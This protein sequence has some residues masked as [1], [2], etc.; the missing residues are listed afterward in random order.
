MEGAGAESGSWRPRAAGP[1]LQARLVIGLL[2]LSLLALVA[3]SRQS[4]RVTTSTLGDV[5]QSLATTP[6]STAPSSTTTAPVAVVA[7]MGTLR[8]PS[9][10]VTMAASVTATELK[11]IEAIKGVVAVEQVDVGTVQLEGA[12]AMTIG[13]DP[14]TF[15][16]FTPAVTAGA[17]R[18]WQY[19]SSGTLASSFEMSRDRKLTL[20]VSVAVTAAGSTA[21]TQHWLGAF[22]S[23]GLPG[24]D[25]VVS[26]QLS[27]ALGLAQNAGLVVSAP[28]VNPFTLQ[29]GIEIAARG[30]S[31][32]LMRPGLALGSTPG[33]A[34]KAAPSVA[35][36]STALTAALSRVGM[37]YVW[38]DTGPN[39]FD[40]SG[41]VGWS[42]A[43]AGIDLPRTAAAQAL[44]GP[45]VPLSQ[46]QPG[47]LL[48]WAFDPTDPTFIDHVA[49]YL[50]HGEMIEAPET[51]ELV[52]VVP[53]Y[54]HDLV[55]AVRIDPAVAAQLYSPWR[56]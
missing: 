53:I 50:G 37:P 34:G 31:V 42:F 51:G 33:V 21:T 16:N 35:Q 12:P 19:I 10:L 32:V 56:R 41:L 39:G 26:H 47:D 5:K 3:L 1:Q 28:T 44:T 29:T 23:V 15:R 9:A 14:G 8:Q 40:C 17:D 11:A 18:L 2:L 20:G 54:A 38:G 25:M 6:P 49:I 27:S 48:F 24:V 43:A 4:R 45:A 55:G 7:S 52:H 13:V 36:L 22:M 30:S 46:I